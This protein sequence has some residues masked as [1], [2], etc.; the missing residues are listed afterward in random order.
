[1]TLRADILRV[2]F[3]SRLADH[4][5]L[6]RKRFE[7]ERLVRAYLWKSA[8]GEDFPPIVCLMGGT[9][10]GKSTL[11]NSLAGRKISDVGTR[12]PFTLKAVILVDEA[13]VEELE[14]CPFLQESGPAAPLVVSSHLDS[15]SPILVDTPDFD[16]V[17]T[18]NRVIAENFFIISDIMM[19]VTSQEKYADLAG[20][21]ITEMAGEWEK[22]AVFVMNKV[23]SQGAY[24]DFIS[25]VSGHGFK[26]SPLMV[27]RLEYP[28]ELIEGLRKRPGFI[29]LL[30]MESNDGRVQARSQELGRLRGRALSSLKDLETVLEAQ[31]QRVESLNNRI[32]AILADVAGD[33]N[34]QLDAI[35]T[36]DVEGQIRHRLENLLRKYD[37][38][39][40]PRMLVRR[41]LREIFGTI[42]DL[43]S[44]SRH[45]T[46]PSEKDIRIEDLEQTRS[47]VRLKPLE[48]AVANLNLRVAELLASDQ[49]LEDLR[50][51]VRK[52]VPRMGPDEIR[53]RYKETFPGIE[54]LLEDEFTRFKDGLSSK[55][56]LKL[57]GSYT[58]WALFIITAE[59]VM[60]GGFTL[61]DALLNTVVM[62]FIPKWLLNL[63]VLD[64]LREIGE[65]VDLKHREALK[66]ILANQAELYTSEFSSLLPAPEMM[67][68]ISDLKASITSDASG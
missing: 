36:E 59:V 42:A 8:L 23:V 65:R 30:H 64:V 14:S 66:S 62:P 38:L 12:R 15:G 54:N 39:F 7:A 33:M 60:G 67:K 41:A 49:S 63:K 31:S 52:S 19:F 56:E 13:W 4:D 6:E 21:K 68:Q 57:Y 26:S 9:G 11:F 61:L 3:D 18:Y 17:Q 45:E 29:D 16:S 51:V 44:E 35:I 32:G 50:T 47:T 24:N 5:L 27:E 40:V 58:L 20:R 1:M 53:L 48:S 10:T 46:A 37:V 2:E 22:A 43:F 34:R 25:F 28:P 55:D